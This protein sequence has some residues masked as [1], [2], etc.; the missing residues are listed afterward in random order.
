MQVQVLPAFL[1]G[2][3]E[4]RRA[5]G[6]QGGPGPNTGE[7]C[8]VSGGRG[9][10][11]TEAPPTPRFHQVPRGPTPPQ[12][13]WPAGGTVHTAALPQGL[14]GTQP[15]PSLQVAGLLGCRLQTLRHSPGSQH[16]ELSRRTP[17]PPG[18]SLAGAPGALSPSC[19][20]PQPSR[21]PQ[22]VDAPRKPPATC[23]HPRPSRP[24]TDGPAAA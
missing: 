12:Q 2:S 24:R 17:R 21:L 15:L 9:R 22:G 3:G 5:G 7:R 14:P 23:A 16:C 13:Q 10:G 4:P 20:P 6:L 11:G 18:Q 8:A 1:S 19:T